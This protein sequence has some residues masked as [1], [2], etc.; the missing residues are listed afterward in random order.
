MVKAP[1]FQKTYDDYMQQIGHL[2]LQALQPILGYRMDGSQAV[3]PLFDQVFIIGSDAILGADGRRA[4]IAVAVLLSK[5]LL[6]S[7]SGQLLPQTLQ[8]FK[9]FKDAAPLVTYFENTIQRKIA[10]NFSGQSQALDQACRQVGGRRYE[11][12]LAY[13]VKYQLL[14]LPRVPVYV[15]FNDAE[16]GFAAQC[17]LLFERRAANYLDMESLTILAGTLSARLSRHRG[18]AMAG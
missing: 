1:I 5:Y 17:T 16:E 10:H 14:G 18:G 4:D 2:D 12:D 7:P 6:M 9:D 8:T 11:Q 3:I 15:L 13:E